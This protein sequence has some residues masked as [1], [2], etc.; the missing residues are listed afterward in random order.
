M[1]YILDSVRNIAHG[2]ANKI[3]IILSLYDTL[4]GLRT[5]QPIDHGLMLLVTDN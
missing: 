3:T 4:N 5:G 1:S 2:Q